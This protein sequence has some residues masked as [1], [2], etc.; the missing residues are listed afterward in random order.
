[1]RDTVATALRHQI[2][3]EKEGKGINAGV[4]IGYGNILGDLDLTLKVTSGGIPVEQYNHQGRKT[5]FVLKAD[6]TLSNGAVTLIGNL[7]LDHYYGSDD[8]NPTRD[9]DRFDMITGTAALLFNSLH[10]NL[11]PAIEAQYTLTPEGYNTLFL[12]PELLLSAWSF[13]DIKMG[14]PI[15][16][17][18]D[19]QEFGV[20]VEFTFVF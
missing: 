8:L 10:R 11:F 20:N 5:I 4:A 14:V 19:G 2:F 3:R 9:Q 18:G 13:C 17:A 16:I 15:R 7:R 12:S 6:K 1:M